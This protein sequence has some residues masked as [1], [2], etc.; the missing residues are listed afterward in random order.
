MRVYGRG[1][2][3]HFLGDLIVYRNLIPL[4]RRLP[5]LPDLR[6]ELEVP[7]G[8]TPRKTSPEYARVIGRIL[9]LAQ[10]MRGVGS[11]IERL[12]YIDPGARS[13]D[14]GSEVPD[15]ESAVHRGYTGERRDSVHQ[16]P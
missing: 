7:T 5:G 14:E 4:D 10:E 6:S 9:E 1:R 16:P 13:R 8:V 15:R 2:V 12:L 11:Q 3:Q